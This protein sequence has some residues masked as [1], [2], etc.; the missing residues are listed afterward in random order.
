GD[1]DRNIV[2]LTH[3]DGIDITISVVS[4]MIGGAGLLT[5]AGTNGGIQLR[6]NDTY[7]AFKTQLE[8]YVRYLR[9]GQPPVPFEETS[10]LMMLVIAGIES[11]EQGGRQIMLSEMENSP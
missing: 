4:D 10:E 7:H 11:R 6:S 2:H 9:T 5:L 1:A 8:S 3:R